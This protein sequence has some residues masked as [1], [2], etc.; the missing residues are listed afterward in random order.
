[1]T[2]V[3]IKVR[4]LIIERSNARC[5]RCGGTLNGI[6]GMSI[7]H[8]DAR[9][10]GGSKAPWLGEPPNLLALCGS[11]TTGC[12][13]R[14]EHEPAWAYKRGLLLRTGD[15]PDET[16]FMDS[17]DRWWLLTGYDKHPMR[18]PHDHA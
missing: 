17:Q 1:M 16:P 12:H 14:I 11:G 18:M 7:H 5:E 3:T 13:G 9:G 4:A 15:R 10:M 2:A 8:R 6:H